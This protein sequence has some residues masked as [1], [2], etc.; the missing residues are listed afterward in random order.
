MANKNKF[1][2]FGVIIA[3]VIVTLF[4]NVSQ[5]SALGFINYNGIEISSG[6]YSTLLN[7]G[8]NEKEIYY[9]D[10]DTFNAN[11]DLD[12]TLLTSETKYFKRVYTGYEIGYD[13]EVTEDEFY[14]HDDLTRGTQVTEYYTVVTTISA[15]NN[16]YRYKISVSWS[17]MPSVK[18]YDIVGIGYGQALTVKNSVVNF[19]YYYTYSSGST[20]TSSQYYDRKVNSAGATTVYKIPENI[21][22]LSLMM[23]YDV[24]KNTNNTYTNLSMC[25]D[26]A[27]AKSNSVTVTLAAHHG[28]SYGGIGLYSDN[29]N[30]YTAIPCTY[31]T[32]SVNW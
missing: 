20:Y 18:K 14:N 31:G 5:A 19:V 10:L 4:A 11:K 22:G 17:N 2:Y 15:V 6:E 21:V 16:D 27:H 12:A 8:F 32:A 26:Y 29:I 25:G 24:V 13:V 23:Y 7:L 3:L 30:L 28:I 1:T 9:M